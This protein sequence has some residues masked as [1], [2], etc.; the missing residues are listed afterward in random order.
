MKKKENLLGVISS[1]EYNATV[2]AFVIDSIVNING[3]IYNVENKKNTSYK[4]NLVLFP[5]G[6][7]KVI[8]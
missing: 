3:L 8:E 4:V 1:P 5:D 6:T 2:T 7:A